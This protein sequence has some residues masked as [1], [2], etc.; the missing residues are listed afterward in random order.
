VAETQDIHCEDFPF[1]SDAVAETH[2]DSE[3]WIQ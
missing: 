3:L 2:T 1:G